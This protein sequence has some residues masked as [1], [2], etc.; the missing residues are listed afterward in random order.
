[1]SIDLSHNR[2]SDLSVGPTGDIAVVSGPAMGQQRVLRRLLTAPGDYIWELTYGAGLPGR[3][4]SPADAD[5]IRAAILSQM[6]MEAAVALTPPPVVDVSASADGTVYAHIRY[7]DATSG[8]Q[9]VLS[10]QTPAN[11]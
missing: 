8:Q 9:Q 4:G 10:L 11:S 6:Q 1:M 2:G 7:V 5:S 3:V